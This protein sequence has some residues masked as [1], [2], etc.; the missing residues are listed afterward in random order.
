LDTADLAI[1]AKE[2]NARFRTSPLLRARRQGLLR[3]LCV[4]LGNTAGR[5]AIPFLHS[6]MRSGETFVP[7]HAAWAIDR[8]ETRTRA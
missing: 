6:L 3:N 4:A 5:E 7:E 8:I 1:T 2:F